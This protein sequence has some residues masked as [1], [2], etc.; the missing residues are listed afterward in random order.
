[1]IFTTR[2]LKKIFHLALFIQTGLLPVFAGKCLAGSLSHDFETP[3]ENR[4]IDIGDNIDSIPLILT[5]ISQE[6][7]KVE[8]KKEEIPIPVEEFKKRVNEWL[9]IL[10]KLSN[11]IKPADLTQYAE[12]R[13]KLESVAIEDKKTANEASKTKISSEPL[14]HFSQRDKL[15]RVIQ[16]NLGVAKNSRDC[17][18]RGQAKRGVNYSYWAFKEN[19]RGATFSEVKPTFQ[20]ETFD[21][22]K[23]LKAVLLELEKMR[24]ELGSHSNIARRDSALVTNTVSRVDAEVERGMEKVEEALRKTGIQVPPRPLTNEELAKQMEE[25]QDKNLSPIPKDYKELFERKLLSDFHDGLD[26]WTFNLRD[27]PK[28]KKADQY[29][30][31]LMKALPEIEFLEQKLKNAP[32]NSSDSKK[33]AK[34]LQKKRSEFL[35]IYS[36]FASLKDYYSTQVISKLAQVEQRFKRVSDQDKKE[37]VNSRPVIDTLDEH[38]KSSDSSSEA[39]IQQAGKSAAKDI[40]QR[41]IDEFRSR[42]IQQINNR[43][44]LGKDAELQYQQALEHLKAMEEALDESKEDDNVPAQDHDS[45]WLASLEQPASTVESKPIYPGPISNSS[46]LNPG[47]RDPALNKELGA[48]DLNDRDSKRDFVDRLAGNKFAAKDR[49]SSF[50]VGEGGKSIEPTEQSAG[51]PLRTFSSSDEVSL[52]GKGSEEG[53][54]GLSNDSSLERKKKLK[55]LT[56]GKSYQDSDLDESN[57]VLE[58]NEREGTISKTF[59]EFKQFFSGFYPNKASNYTNTLSQTKFQDGGKNNELASVGLKE[60]AESSLLPGSSQSG[61]DDAEGGYSVR[62]GQGKRA[63]FQSRAAKSINDQAV[64]N[65][66]SVSFVSSSNPVLNGPNSSSET[67]AKALSVENKYIRNADGTWSPLL[68]N[69]RTGTKDGDKLE[70]AL[71]GNVSNIGTQGSLEKNPEATASNLMASLDG[72]ELIEPGG[73]GEKDPGAFKPTL[74]SIS[75]F[76]EGLYSS[77]GAT[78]TGDISKLLASTLNPKESKKWVKNRN[79]SSTQMFTQGSLGSLQTKQ[80]RDLASDKLS[81]LE[82]LKGWL[83]IN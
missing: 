62:K 49:V 6:L 63:G 47:P 48:P 54:E 27:L 33:L 38:L 75:Q 25:F 70:M 66:T 41:E 14:F 44:K 19:S 72:I 29:F 53:L 42:I 28:L 50:E 74:D 26:K 24:R 7:Q 65:V 22:G 35:R 30:S 11:E 55:N 16:W 32:K 13:K 60:D 18:E 12:L 78:K 69:K 79:D 80:V 67:S 15:Y 2:A 23:H 52:V 4:L 5:R 58:S 37:P 77:F 64:N 20:G 81:F 36:D 68:S 43:G 39:G 21:C 73:D 59:N 56:R 9:N 57:K 10:N 34:D 71:G 51:S 17:V 76:L 31:E 83:G 40:A 46:A 3:D 8:K 82:R 61:G 1:M 45:R